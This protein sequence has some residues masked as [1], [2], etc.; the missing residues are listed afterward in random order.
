[1]SKNLQQSHVRR[2]VICIFYISL[3]GIYFLTLLVKHPVS[4]FNVIVDAVELGQ[5]YWSLYHKDVVCFQMCLAS[6]K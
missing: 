4:A 3:I 1:M 6:S 5:W 2:H